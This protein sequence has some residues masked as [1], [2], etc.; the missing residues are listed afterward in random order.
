[1]EFKK[2]LLSVPKPHRK[3][4]EVNEMSEFIRGID[5]ETGVRKIR[6][7]IHL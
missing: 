5:A 4:E 2:D 3:W 6:C 7:S 1:M